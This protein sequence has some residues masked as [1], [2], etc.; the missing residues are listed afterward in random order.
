MGQLQK[1]AVS[2]PPGPAP[3][4]KSL[5]SILRLRINRIY[6][7]IIFPL[8]LVFQ[9]VRHGKKAVVVCRPGALGDV[10]CTLPLCAEIRKRHPGKLLVF[11]THADYK[12]LVLLSKAA[13]A[14][15]GAKSWTWPF[16]L[17]DKFNVLGVVEGVYNPKTTDELTP[18]NGAQVHLINDLAGSCDLTIPNADRQ[19]HLFPA[20]EL[21]KETQ[22]AHGLTEEVIKGRLVIGINCGHTWPVRMWDV[23][24]WQAFVD[25]IHAEYQAV[26]LQFGLTKGSD[27]EYEH[28]RGVRLLSNRLRSDELVALI[29]GC[30]LIVS[31]DSGPVHVGGAVGVPVVGLFGAVNPRYR[32][33]PDS[34][35]AGVTSDVPCLF[36]HHTT[37]KGHW[38]T[39][40]PNDIRCMKEL[41]VE[42]VFR[43]V[44]ERL[45]QSK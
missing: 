10:I 32:L 31:I 20:P 18:Q 27:D 15:Y 14:V 29:A 11:L 3:A 36:C 1:S 5:R 6:D 39:G 42:T 13:D 12:N 24:K 22:L 26:V 21:I 28:L 30:K 43:T 7:L 37:P 25:K 16:S 9:C 33:P 40:C 34:P 38:Q 45:A 41:D 8:W 17:P 44:K 4:S 23:Q 2:V 19:P 35:A